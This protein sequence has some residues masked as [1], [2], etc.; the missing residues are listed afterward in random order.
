MMNP[1]RRI[2]RASLRLALGLTGATVLAGATLPA[3]AADVGV[4]ISIGQPGFYGQINIGEIP[5][6]PQVIYPQPVIIERNPHYAL[7]PLYL[8]VPPGHEKHWAKHCREYHACD[9][10]VY[11]VRDEWYRNTVMPHYQ[12]RG[13]AKGG[14]EDHPRGHD[15]R[16]DDRRG[17]EHER[18]D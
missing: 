2:L 12:H 3:R 6:P 11:F 1:L 10:Q 18:R 17:G 4:S 9:R 14:R 7:P 15:D 13:E 16:H 8:R 5:Q